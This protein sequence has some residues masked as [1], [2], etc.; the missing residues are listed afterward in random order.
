M[1]ECDC[2]EAGWCPHFKKNLVGRLWEIAKGINIDPAVADQ[3]KQLWLKQA[4]LEVPSLEA[5]KRQPDITRDGCKC[6][7]PT[8]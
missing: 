4:G 7:K 3:Y 5:P 2:K 6:N 8:T 1:V